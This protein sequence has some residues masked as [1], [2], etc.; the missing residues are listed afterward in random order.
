MSEKKSTLMQKVQRFGGAMFTPVLFFAVFGIIV[1]FAT[2]FKNN[3]VFGSLADPE[4]TWYKVWDIIYNGANTVFKQMPL[5]FAIGL[6]VS[7]AKKQQA[8]ACLEIFVI[9]ATFLYL[10]S[11]ILQY[12]GPVF[13]VDFESVERTSGLA[14]IASVRT[15]DMGIVGALI[16]AGIAVYL[17]N[18]F[19]DMEVPKYVETFKGSPMVVLIG[20]FVMIPVSVLACLIWPHVQDGIASVQSFLAST[21]VF[22]VGMYTFLE[23][24]MIP[25]GLHH[26]IYAPFLYDS[27]IVDGGIKAYWVAHLSEFASMKGSL[28][29]MFPAGGFAL[30]GMSKMFAPLGISGAI[31]VTAKPNKKKKV[32]ALFNSGI[33][34]S[35]VHRNY[36][37]TGIYISFYRSCFVSVSCSACRIDVSNHICMWNQWRFQFGTD[38]ECV[39]ELGTSLEHTWWK[40]CTSDCDWIDF[41]SH[42]FCTVP[43]IDS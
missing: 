39:S 19:F 26:F 36:R 28:A 31:Y 16:I 12:W 13:G 18:K 42:L 4:T 20:F 10:T 23:R 2:L 29:A 14:T 33:D 11:S 25:F 9:Y 8:R 1:G 35:N 38:P 37:A 27:A 6:P 7:L 24:L 21:G 15:L 32:L 43:C 41:L 40:L 3:L 34:Y 30:T 5:I 17:H 22:G